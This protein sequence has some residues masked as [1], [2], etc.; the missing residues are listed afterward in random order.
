MNT[1]KWV[2]HF[3]GGIQHLQ[4]AT[5]PRLACRCLLTTAMPRRECRLN[6]HRDESH[7]PQANVWA[8]P[9]A[10]FLYLHEPMARP[11]RKGRAQAPV[12]A[13]SVPDKQRQIVSHRTVYESRPSERPG[14]D[15]DATAGSLTSGLSFTRARVSRLMY[16]R[17]TV[18]SSFVSS[19]I[20]P[21]SRMMA[22]SLGKMPTTDRVARIERCL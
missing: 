8:P 11:Y 16:R 4:R 5:A 13:P 12:S 3:S 17:A 10:K 19:M 22:S 9:F 2:S 20:A 15:Q 6:P 7:A 1:F 14:S 18:H 21:T